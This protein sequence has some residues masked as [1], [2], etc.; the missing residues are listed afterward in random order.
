MTIRKAA[1]GIALGS[2]LAV[3]GSPFAR[4]VTYDATIQYPHPSGQTFQIANSPTPASLSLSDTA[5]LGSGSHAFA[6]ASAAAGPGSVGGSSSALLV[7]GPG[8]LGYT[9]V[10]QEYSD[11]YSYDVTISGPAGTITTFSINF[12]FDGSLSAAAAGGGNWYG[13]ANVG[14]GGG[15]NTSFGGYPLFDASGI[16]L[17]SNGAYSATGLF[18]P[19]TLAPDGSLHAPFTSKT[20][21]ARAGETI[22]FSLQISTVAAANCN[23]VC[24][25]GSATASADFAHTLSLAATGAVF[26]LDPGF[27]AS[28]ADGCIVNNAYVCAT[29]PEPSPLPLAAFGFALCLVPLRRSR[30]AG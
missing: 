28:S 19:L 4:A 13:W 18:A 20:F 7:G 12:D 30:G 3:A 1:F 21:S 8:F 2:V 25:E 22:N 27:T 17:D 15:V 16:S 11:F 23:F 9:S 5:D 6:A 26:N 14:V 10:G 24:P 29:T